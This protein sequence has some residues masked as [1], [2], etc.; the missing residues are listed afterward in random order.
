MAIKNN[1]K[2]FDLS[3]N[4]ETMQPC[5][6][7]K[8]DKHNWFILSHFK[9]FI[10]N[11]LPF[12]RLIFKSTCHIFLNDMHTD[13]Q[14]VESLLIFLSDINDY[15]NE[16]LFC[17]VFFLFAVWCIVKYCAQSCHLPRF[18]SCVLA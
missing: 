13:C 14:N 8:N 10:L 12:E 5:K 2:S 9:A 6:N 16:N 18:A 4:V 7:N 15:M 17:F 11:I 3:T 1:A